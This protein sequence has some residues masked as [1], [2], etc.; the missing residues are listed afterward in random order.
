MA[1]PA[2]DAAVVAPGGVGMLA[3]PAALIVVVSARDPIAPI[4]M[5][6]VAPVGV[7]IV[8]SAPMRSHVAS[9]VAMHLLP[10]RPRCEEGD[11]GGPHAVARKHPAELVAE[12]VAEVISRRG[13]SRAEGHTRDGDG[14]DHECATNAHS[15]PLA[16][17]R[18]RERHAL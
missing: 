11:L 15:L 5:F 14:R 12:S 10:M 17:S 6:V 9:V 3:E 8:V 16:A 2:I 18:V 4:T 13:R 1:I 7:A